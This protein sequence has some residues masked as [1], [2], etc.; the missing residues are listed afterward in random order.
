MKALILSVFILFTVSYS[1]AQKQVE[2]SFNSKDGNFL[3]Q[4]ADVYSFGPFKVIG[5]TTN[6]D[7]ASFEK[8]VKK[9]SIVKKF[10]YVNTTDKTREAV[11]SFSTND[12]NAIQNFFKTIHVSKITVNDRSFSIEQKEEFKAYLKELKQKHVEKQNAIQNQRRSVP[13]QRIQTNE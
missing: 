8:L 9:Q 5:L 13:Q 11:I 7:Y 2:I 4:D 10:E 6:N 3:H 1:F 12:E